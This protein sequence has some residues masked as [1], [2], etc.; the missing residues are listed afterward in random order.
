MSGPRARCEPMLEAGAVTASAC[1]GLVAM[2]EPSAASTQQRVSDYT[3]GQLRIAYADPPYP[4]CA[5]LYKDHPDYNGEVDHE[6]LITELV[7]YDGWALSTSSQALQQI[8]F[9]CPEH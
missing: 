6:A 2:P 7:G 3:S 5:H 4:G 1:L 8:L 9:F